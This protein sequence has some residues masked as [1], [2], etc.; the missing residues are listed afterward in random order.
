MNLTWS[1]AKDGNS[2]TLNPGGIN[3]TGN[4]IQGSGHD[5]QIVNATTTSQ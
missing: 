1:G 4:T 3:E 5:T 2:F